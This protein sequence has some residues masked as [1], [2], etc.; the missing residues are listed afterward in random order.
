L[1]GNSRYPDFTHKKTQD[2]LWLNSKWKPPWVDMELAAMPTGTVQLGIF[3]WNSRLHKYL[4]TGQYKKTIELFEQ[5][6]EENVIPNAFSFVQ[7]LNACA[8]LMALDD[9]LRIHMQ[10]I[11]SGCESDLYVGNSLID[12]YAKC[13]GIDYAWLVFSKMPIRNVI[14]WNAM[15][16]GLV[17]C[18]QEQKAMELFQQMQCRGVAPDRV[19]FVGLLHA[20]ARV[21][22]LKDGKQIHE[23]IIQSGFESDLFVA[24]S[25]IDMYA[26]CG[27]IEDAQRVFDRMP[28]RD[29]AA[30]NAMLLGHVR[31]GQGQEALL[32]SQKMQ[33]EG[34]KPDSITFVGVLNACAS[35]ASLDEG[36][37][38]HELIIQNGYQSHGFVGNSLVDMY[39][40]CGS[41][42]DAR[43]VFDSMPRRDVVAWNAMIFGY[44]KC[45]QGQEALDL[46]RQ[47]CCEGVKPVPIT[48]VGMLNA[49]AG[50][51]ALEEGRCIHTKIIQSGCES[52]VYVGSSLVDMYAKCGSIEDA[53][54]VFDR[55]RTRDA[56]AWTTM[57]LGYVKCSQGKNALELFQKMLCEGVEPIPATFTAVLSAC[58]SVVALEE[59]RLVHEYISR[60]GWESDLFVGSSL[61][62]M[63]AKCGSVEDALRVFNKMPRH[64]LI[65]WNT[66][67][68]GYAM[69]GHG[70]EAV[71]HFE[72]MWDRSVE[73]DK[74]TFICL[75][76]ACNHA[77]LVEEGLQYFESMKSVYGISATVEH[78]A[79]M[80]GLLGRAGH[81][82]EAEDL[83][84]VMHCEPNAPV[85]RA[86]L[87]AC[88]VHGNIEIGEHAAKKVIELDPGDAAGY[89]L[90]SNIYAA[91]GKWDL[92]S[93]IQQQRLE[94][95]VNKQ[96][97]CTWIEVNHELH[98]FTV[99]DQ[100]HPQISEI[101]AELSRLSKQMN[102]IG[103]V[104]DT[105]FVLHDVE[106]EEKV[107]RL[108]Y[109]SEKLA[110]AFGLISTPPG[111]T[112]RI[113]KNL[114]VCGDCHTATK[115]IAKIVERGIIVRDANRFHHFNKDGLCSCRDYW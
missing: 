106:E 54:E 72:Q 37:H 82:A 100:D 90:L 107:V 102:D 39:A 43:Q 19:T 47:M 110:I 11:Q 99:D 62:D 34:V 112:L 78:Y 46:S 80:V 7:V 17:K 1:Q 57:I 9:G 33:Q 75:L 109:H 65:S 97:G 28:T 10:I 93:N 3:L 22:V 77:G 86:L 67:L 2:A 56:V 60:S 49:C 105:K 12:M 71:E 85:W 24:S 74:V 66:M 96:P 73:I 55:M 101:H 44:V 53:L 27:S 13:G 92:S 95:G 35:V 30:W 61:I 115:F 83:I 58:A 52:D 68:G 29:V 21:A 4:T 32:L 23:Q 84:K 45:G 59:G 5:M 70:K 103:Y 104:P 38:V 51:T 50:I 41:I 14:S 63:Y 79:C 94:R 25:L 48:F 16:L 91:A 40:K 20:C 81:L 89:V 98:S 114:R 31:G 87:G 18:G 69:H 36:R 88:R 113:F 108:C 8:G 111:T 26:K 42:E 6:Q 15:I 76:S 64:D